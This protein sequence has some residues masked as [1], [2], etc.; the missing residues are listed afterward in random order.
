MKG[1]LFKCRPE[2]IPGVNKPGFVKPY[3]EVWNRITFTMVKLRRIHFSASP[4]TLNVRHPFPALLSSTLL[5]S[6]IDMRSEPLAPKKAA[7]KCTQ[8]SCVTHVWSGTILTLFVKPLSRCFHASHVSTVFLR[9]EKYVFFPPY[10]KHISGFILP[11]QQKVLSED[12]TDDW[13]TL[14]HPP[15]QET[16]VKE[17]ILWMYTYTV[18]SVTLRTVCP[19][20]PTTFC[21]WTLWVVVFIVGDF[22]EV[23]FSEHQNQ[24]LLRNFKG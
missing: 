15:S 5:Q 23:L 8:L 17:V 9:W 20:A 3:L 4:S 22:P 13:G 24:Q 2:T 16:C 6:C 11:D 19:V 14:P 7:S 10:K 21:V 1:W 18:L 12:E